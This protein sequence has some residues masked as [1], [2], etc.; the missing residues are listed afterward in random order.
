MAD[1]QAAAT[2]ARTEAPKV[3]TKLPFAEQMRAIDPNVFGPEPAGEPAAEAAPEAEAVAEEKPKR[4]TSKKPTGAS[5]RG[6]GSLRTASSWRTRSGTSRRRAT[7]STS[8]R[9]SALT[10]GTS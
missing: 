8:P 10:T 4:G 3:D 6:R 5:R 7:T 2:E 1:E 9:R